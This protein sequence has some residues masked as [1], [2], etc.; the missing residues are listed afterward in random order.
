M[1]N[2]LGLIRSLPSQ[3]PDKSG[4]IGRIV[5]N[6][7]AFRKRNRFEDPARCFA[8]RARPASCATRSARCEGYH[9]PMISWRRHAKQN[10]TNYT[11]IPRGQEC[12]A[13][14][15]PRR[16]GHPHESRASNKKQRKGYMKTNS[17]WKWLLLLSVV[18]GVGGCTDYYGT[19]QAYRPAI[20]RGLRC[21]WLQ[22]AR[23]RLRLP[24]RWL[25]LFQWL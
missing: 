8:G 3:S 15:N 19:Y 24:L 10:L 13:I 25:R 16:A 7:S 5:P 21:I 2:F 17:K 11:M 12:M 4:V 23:L 6:Y 22:P 1:P 18:I 20:L 9:E 14:H